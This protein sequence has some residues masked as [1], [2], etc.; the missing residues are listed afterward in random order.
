MSLENIF[1]LAESCILSHH[2]DYDADDVDDDNKES[3][4]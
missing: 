3:R 2:D 4:K 1:K